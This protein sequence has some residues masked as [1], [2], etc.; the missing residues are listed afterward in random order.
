M[1]EDDLRHSFVVEPQEAGTRLDVIL[2]RRWPERPRAFFQKLLADGAITT[3]GR[4]LKPSEKP[5]AGL[6]IDI[7]WPEER[8]AEPPA[9][10]IP[11]DI[12][13]EDEN[14]LVLNKQAG[15]VV[16]PGSGLQ[17][18]TLVNALL[19][20][21]EETFSA[22]LD[23]DQRPGIVHRL[24]GDT[25]G[26]MVVAKDLASASRLKKQFQAH[27]VQ[28]TYLAIVQGTFD[29]T[30]AGSC[31]QPIGRSPRYRWKS[32]IRTDGKEAHTRF[33]VLAE[34]HGCSLLA[35]RI[36]TGRTHQIRVHSAWLGHPVLGDQTY[37]PRNPRAS[38]GLLPAPP[39]QMLHAWRLTL[40]HPATQESQTF[41]APL[42]DDFRQMLS[43]L[44][45]SSEIPD[46]L[47][48][49]QDF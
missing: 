30:L 10:E 9:Q 2:V 20:H 25:S 28:K 42:P 6:C 11:L 8:P 27:T 43:A 48:I 3:G 15:L 14:I 19:A 13:Y 31:D 22:M 29:G 45:D 17:D 23:A 46:F 49:L 35:F 24:D 36:L 16:H 41:Y 4:R 5:S 34:G 37:G 40:T 38:S 7:V 32:A 26:V 44:L 1:S 47:E 18:G 39:R 21:D 12:L 33:R